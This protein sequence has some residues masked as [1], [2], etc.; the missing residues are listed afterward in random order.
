MRGREETENWRICTC[1]YTRGCKAT[2]DL[3]WDVHS[4]SLKRK[5]EMERGSSFSTH[6]AADDETTRRI[7]YSIFRTKLGKSPLFALLGEAYPRDAAIPKGEIGKAERWKNSL[8]RI[9]IVRAEH[10]SPKTREFPAKRSNPIPRACYFRHWIRVRTRFR[11]G[12]CS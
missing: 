10:V 4:S 2:R 11:H 7:A 1:L 3:W 9:V 6:H 5:R 12:I 8:S